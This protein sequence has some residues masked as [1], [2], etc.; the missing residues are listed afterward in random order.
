LP[1]SAEPAKIKEEIEKIFAGFGS[2]PASRLFGSTG[3][4][5]RPQSGNQKSASGFCSK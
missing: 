3:R 2:P 5:C 1:P 4:D